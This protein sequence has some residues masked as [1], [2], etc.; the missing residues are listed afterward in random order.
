MPDIQLGIELEYPR[1]QSE[2]TKMTKAGVNSNSLHSTVSDDSS[3]LPRHSRVTRDGTVG[4]ELVTS[5]PIEPETAKRWYRDS[6][7]ALEDDYGTPFAPTSMMDDRT[8]AG[9]HTH[10]SPLTGEEAQTLYE[11]S[12]EPW[13]QVFVCTGVA[14]QEAPNYRVFRDTGYCRFNSF[15]HGRYSAINQRGGN[16]YEWRLVE[17]M[18]P[19]HYEK[20]ITFLEKF[21]RD[22]EDARTYVLDLLEDPDEEITAIERAKEIGVNLDMDVGRVTR[23]PHS[24]TEEW[25]NRIRNGDG[26]PYIYRVSIPDMGDYYLF[27]SGKTDWFEVEDVEFRRTTILDASD[28]S[29]VYDPTVTEQVRQTYRD[30][31]A[32][33]QEGHKTPA[34]DK[35][36]EIYKKK[37]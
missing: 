10:I 23:S 17:P 24:A 14:E 4:L 1:A 25:F 16:H 20:V 37:Q 19:S 27:R 28:L 26:M 33:Q 9:L 32:Q 2:A 35:L 31:Q 29:R 7:R 22:R 18:L 5:G 8:S 13:M 3:Y 36:K 12:N 15:N 30:H 21:K 11:W 6:V 34:T